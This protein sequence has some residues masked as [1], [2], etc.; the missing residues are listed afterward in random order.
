[1]KGDLHCHTKFSDGSESMED[2]L[3]L[4]GRIGLDYV[5]LTDHDT[6][7]SFSRSQ[8][9]GQRLGVRVIPGVEFSTWDTQRK[10]KVH[11][12]CYLPAK[13]DRLQSACIRME[14]TRKAAGNEMAKRVMKLYPITPESITKY[15]AGA[16]VIYKQHIMRALLDCGYTDRIY[17]DLYRTLFDS[18]EGSC[19]VKNSYPD[20]YHIVELIHSAGGV[21]VIAHPGAYH[22]MELVEEMASKGIL[23]GVEA[24]HPRNAEKDTAQLLEYA[25]QYD[26]LVTGGSDFHGMYSG[27]DQNYIGKCTTDDDMIRRLL[28][29]SKKI[30][31]DVR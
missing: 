30:R 18:K 22:S 10:R 19:L 31:Q 5:A 26:L 14:T 29:L 20:A 13:P 16:T 11:I 9:L 25:R 8:L 24:Y 15:S 28:S 27:S 3:A 23:D 4:A 12:L 17:G 21:A 6:T 2:V 1:M 7:K